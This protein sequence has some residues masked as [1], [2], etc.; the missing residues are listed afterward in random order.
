MNRLKRGGRTKD[1]TG[2]QNL[3]GLLTNLENHVLHHRL[4][5]QRKTGNQNAETD[6]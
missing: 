1:L 3:A 4:R 5:R 2:F 6:A